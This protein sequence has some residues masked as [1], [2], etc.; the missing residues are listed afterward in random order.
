MSTTR[1]ERFIAAPRDRVYAALL[2]PVALARWRVPH[3]M[4]C[5]VHELDAREGGAVRVS[6]TYEGGDGVGKTSARTDTYHGRFVRLVPDELVVEED[7]F[8]TDDPA[9]R[10]AMTSTIALADVPGGTQLVAVHEGVPDGVAPEANEQGW[11]EALGRLA[12]L[13]E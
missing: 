3:G 5:D 11:Q 13:V 8:E 4:T 2:D 10:G 7:E 12:A 9:M 1:V 6:L